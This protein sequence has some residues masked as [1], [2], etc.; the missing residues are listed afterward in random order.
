M[1][2]LSLIPCYSLIREITSLIGGF[3]S[4]LRFLG[5]LE[6]KVIWTVGYKG[7]KMAKRPKIKK[8]P[9]NF[10]VSREYAGAELLADCTI[11]H[12]VPSPLPV[13][14]GILFKFKISNG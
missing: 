7:Q 1:V 5:N 8:F 6:N 13:S 10:P 12:L 2:C 4:L 11:S 14:A 9:V 3:N